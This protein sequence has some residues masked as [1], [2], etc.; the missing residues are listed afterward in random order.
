MNIKVIARKM[1]YK[2]K[3]SCKTREI[4]VKPKYSAIN[5]LYKNIY[6][7]ITINKDRKNNVLD[8]QCIRL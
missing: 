8:K 6:E 4:K 5:C 3:T 7:L 2:Y 1:N